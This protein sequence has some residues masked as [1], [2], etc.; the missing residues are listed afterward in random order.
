MGISL[1]LGLAGQTFYRALGLAQSDALLPKEWLERTQRVSDAR[2]KTYVPMLGTALL[3]KATDDRISSL[4]LKESAGHNAYNARGPGHE[5]LVPLCV[6][7]GISLRTTGREPLNNQPFFRYDRVSE[8]MKILSTNQADFDYLVE[9]LEKVDFLRG[10]DALNAL[11]AFLRVRL[12]DPESSG[13]Q[14]ITDV[15]DAGEKVAQLAAEHALEDPEGGR[16]GQALVAAALDLL[17][18]QVLTRRVNNPSAMIPG[19][20]IIGA[21]ESG[22][23]REVKQRY[24]ADHEIRQLVER[25]RQAGWSKVAV[26][27]FA[28]DHPV[29]DED[30]LREFAASHGVLLEIGHDAAALIRRCITNSSLPA[31]EAARLFATQYAR[32]MTELECDLEGIQEWVSRASAKPNAISREDSGGRPTPSFPPMARGR[33]PR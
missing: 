25:A 31:M 20:V 32:R 10:E 33:H 13:V 23:V 29:L 15:L 21:A 5:V 11:A 27:A 12:L 22:I 6:A 8:S 7:E 4:A 19:D 28:T 2:A 9:T 14:A 17:S 1:D 30:A 26:D 18:D 24:I 16:R 3:A